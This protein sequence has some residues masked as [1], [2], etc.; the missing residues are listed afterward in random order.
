MFKTKLLCLVKFQFYQTKIK[1]KIK[2]ENNQTKKRHDHTSSRSILASMGL[3]TGGQCT[4]EVP[5]LEG[6]SDLT[7]QTRARLSPRLIAQFNRA[8]STKICA[9]QLNN[10][11]FSFAYNRT[12]KCIKSN[13]LYTWAIL[14]VMRFVKSFVLPTISSQ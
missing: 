8:Q 5:R 10:S 11:Q 13:E 7:E 12:V 1:L 6:C 9:M 2:S 3:Q 4:G 14:K